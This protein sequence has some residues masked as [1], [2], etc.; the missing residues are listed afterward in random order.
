MHATMARAPT[1]EKDAPKTDARFE[2]VNIET[3]R[4]FPELALLQKS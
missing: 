2:V 1:I 4:F 3:L